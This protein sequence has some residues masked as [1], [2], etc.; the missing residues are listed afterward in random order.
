VAAI[1]KREFDARQADAVA[2]IEGDAFVKDL[3]ADLGAQIDPAA[4]KPI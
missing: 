1:E 3:I 2:S 4:I